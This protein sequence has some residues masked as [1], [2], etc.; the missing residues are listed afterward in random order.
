VQESVLEGPIKPAD[1]DTGVFLGGR[2]S[3]EEVIKY[4]GISENVA[5]GMRSSDRIWAQPN[6]HATQMERAQERAAL[7][8]FGN[9]KGTNLIPHFTL[10]SIPNDVVIARASKLGVSLGKSPSQ[11]ESS[12]ASIKNLDL[13][14]SL[15]MLKRKEVSTDN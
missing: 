9:L 13:E 11:I 12:V 5:K 14:R 1:H 2:Y 10:A 4:G 7:M 8:D 6:A 15:V 3:K